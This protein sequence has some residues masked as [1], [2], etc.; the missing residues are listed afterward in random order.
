[1]IAGVHQPEREFGKDVIE[2]YNK[3]WK[4]N[5]NSIHLHLT[6]NTAYFKKNSKEYSFDNAH[7]HIEMLG[8]IS[9]LHPRLVLDIHFTATT[10][11]NCLIQFSGD[12]L[13]DKEDIQY[14]L[15]INSLI[16]MGF[17][18]YR[19]SARNPL[20]ANDTRFVYAVL[21]TFIP[22]GASQELKRYRTELL[23]SYNKEA[24]KNNMPEMKRLELLFETQLTEMMFEIGNRKDDTYLEA[25]AKTS[26]I[27]NSLHN[28]LKQNPDFLKKK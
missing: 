6:Q 11:E 13:A 27:T 1:V 16:N 24:M 17:C 5:D 22:Y 26:K 10:N 21:E 8:I 23:E 20:F 2:D 15:L 3:K 28:F 7:P 25:V 19:A 14:Y 4:A 12:Q 9:D 18:Q